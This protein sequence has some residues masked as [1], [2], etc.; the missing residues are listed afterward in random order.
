MVNQATIQAI[1]NSQNQFGLSTLVT[2]IMVLS[3]ACKE[4]KK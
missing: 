2:I 1:S 4:N 3:N